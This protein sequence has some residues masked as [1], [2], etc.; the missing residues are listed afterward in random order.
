M[1]SYKSTGMNPPQAK[2]LAE[3]FIEEL[4][5]LGYSHFEI[6]G[7][8]RRKEL[9]IGDVDLIVEGPLDRVTQVP[10]AEYK[11][12]GDTRVTLVYEGQQINV[13]T[14][15]PENWGAMLFYLTGPTSYCIA[16]RMKAKVKGWH[17]DQYGVKDQTGKIIA[18]KTEEEIYKV[19][20]KSWKAPEKRGR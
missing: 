20:D 13:F 17:M 14:A 5:K 1:P 10:G 16:Y 3:K 12:G 9:K 15:T 11:N 6:A 4:K 19:F 7:S 2:A 18:A 8:M